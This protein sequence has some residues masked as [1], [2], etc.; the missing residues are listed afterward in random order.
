MAFLGNGWTSEA[1]FIPMK[2]SMSL[3]VTYSD[4]YSRQQGWK[5]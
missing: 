3:Y 2:A 1:L 5:R 4:V